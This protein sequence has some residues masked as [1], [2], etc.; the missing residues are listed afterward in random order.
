MTAFLQVQSGII[1][2]WALQP[3]FSDPGD[4]ME[5]VLQTSFGAQTEV[6]ILCQLFDAVTWVETEC[7]MCHFTIIRWNPFL[8]HRND[9]EGLLASKSVFRMQS[10]PVQG[11]YLIKLRSSRARGFPIFCKHPSS[12]GL[13]ESDP[14]AVSCCKISCAEVKAG[15]TCH[16]NMRHRITK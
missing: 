15:N 8:S 6:P 10:A 2:K 4:F 12:A 14:L 5:Q 3:H 7:E 1:S 16:G 13:L 9:S 11:S